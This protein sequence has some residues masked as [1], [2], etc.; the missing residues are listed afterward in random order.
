MMDR[1]IKWIDNN[2]QRELY[3]DRTIDRM[4]AIT[5]NRKNDRTVDRHTV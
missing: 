1:Q 2:R 4:M 5:I 3:N